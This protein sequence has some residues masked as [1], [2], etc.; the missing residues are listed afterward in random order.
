MASSDFRFGMTTAE[1]MKAAKKAGFQLR[2]ETAGKKYRVH[3]SHPLLKG[4]KMYDTPQ[5]GEAA[6]LLV[7]HA[8]KLQK[9]LKQ[10]D[11]DTSA[12]PPTSP[13]EPKGPADY[14]IL[15]PSPLELVTN[16]ASMLVLWLD[17]QAKNGLRQFTITQ[18][19]NKKRAELGLPDAESVMAALDVLCD[20]NVISEGSVKSGKRMYRAFQIN[21]AIV[22]DVVGAYDNK[23]CPPATFD[24]KAPVTV[25]VVKP[26]V[27]TQSKSA[28][29]P[30]PAP[31]PAEPA[32]QS[33][34]ELLLRRAAQDET[35]IRRLT[36]MYIVGED[37]EA[38]AQMVVASNDVKACEKLIRR[39]AELNRGMRGSDV[40]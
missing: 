24:P 20:E 14:G 28:S 38:L 21:P 9:Q 8:A 3:I 18:L 31:P 19:N 2:T 33:F 32:G 25:P 11:A 30:E 34:E 10:L 6:G 7:K 16:A 17:E 12:P 5:H 23:S 22:G 4:A 36:D 39:V 1:F 13:P 15:A 35:V 26:K 29:A 37:Y 40:K 27:I